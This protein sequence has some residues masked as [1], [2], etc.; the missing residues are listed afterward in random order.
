[1]N[2]T[3]VGVWGGLVLGT[4]ELCD[5]SSCIN[6]A[7]HK[8]ENKCISVIRYRQYKSGKSLR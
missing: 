7:F 3:G 4:L 8:A 1:M 6:G 2:C 5:K